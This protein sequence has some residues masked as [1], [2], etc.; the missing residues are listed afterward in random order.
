[1]FLIM[2]ASFRLAKAGCIFLKRLKLSKT[3]LKRAGVPLASPIE[4][5]IHSEFG[6]SGISDAVSL[7]DIQVPGDGQPAILLADRQ[8]TGGYPRIATIITADLSRAA[9]SRPGEKMRFEAVAEEEALAALS[10][11]RRH[12]ADLPKAV[13][14]LL[15]DPK[16]LPNLLEFN[17]IS[18]VVSSDTQ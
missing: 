4:T 1:M 11:W 3:D 15:R 17:L 9:Q 5:P 6:L 12:L 14:P 16:K 18:G 8:P 10:Q 7:G 2:S 13:Q